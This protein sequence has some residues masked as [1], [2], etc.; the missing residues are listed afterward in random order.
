MSVTNRSPYPQNPRMPSEELL[1]HFSFEPLSDAN[2]PDVFSC[3]NDDL[4]DFLLND[5]LNHQNANVAMTTL[6]KYDNE[7]VAFYSLATDCISLDPKEKARI[8]DEYGIPYTEFPALKI[9]RLGVKKESQLKRI[10][11]MIVMNIA[12]IASNLQDEIGLRFLSVDAYPASKEFY[13]RQGFYV[14]A[15]ENEQKPPNISMRYD[16]QPV[17]WEED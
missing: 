2:K 1:Q 9:C 17:T 8:R 15:H 10:G 13:A 6:V 16:L 5:A 11:Q 14:N 7:I 4:D 3:D 12:G